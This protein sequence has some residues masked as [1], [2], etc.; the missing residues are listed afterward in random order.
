MPVAHKGLVPV[1]HKGLVPVAHKGLVPVA[2]KGLDY[3]VM[4]DE[5]SVCESL[6]IE[7]IP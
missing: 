1:A 5:L 2:H 3:I 7:S 4:I 6:S